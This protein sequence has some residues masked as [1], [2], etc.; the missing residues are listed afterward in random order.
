MT[1]H[2]SA[3]QKGLEEYNPF[4]D[5]AAVS[6]PP[7]PSAPEPASVGARSFHV[8]SA[9]VAHAY[10]TLGALSL[11]SVC[12]CTHTRVFLCVYVRVHVCAFL[13]S[14]S[15]LHTQRHSS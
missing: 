7:A 3:A 6:A 15:I 13:E 12:V 11:G 1:Q 2:T 4:A 5:D 8:P 9:S 10:L 14:R